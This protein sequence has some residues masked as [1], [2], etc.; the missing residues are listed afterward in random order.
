MLKKTTTTLDYLFGVTSV[1]FQFRGKVGKLWFYTLVINVHTIQS[2]VLKL[3]KMDQM[4]FGD[5]GSAQ[6]R[7]C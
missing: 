4:L 2:R 3:L 6:A 7:L 1:C 5:F